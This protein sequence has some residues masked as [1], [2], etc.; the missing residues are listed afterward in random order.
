MNT[1][2]NAE[3]ALWRGLDDFS[4]HGLIDRIDP[5]SRIVA[6]VLFAGVVVSLGNL[7]AL[8]AGLGVGV[9][10]L[11]LS[12]T[13]NGATLKRVAAMD[14]FIIFMLVILPFTT[15]GAALFTIWGV[16][17][18]RE[19][20]LKAIEIMLKANAIVM[21]LL[22][23]VGSMEATTL[24]HGLYRLRCPEKLVHLMLFT[25]RYLS[26]LHDEYLRMR[27]AMR[28][29]G[30]LPRNNLHTYKSFGYLLGMMLVRSLERSER[31][32]EAMKCRGFD[33]RFF[34][35]A[36]GRFGLWDAVYAVIVLS[37]LAGLTVLEMLHVTLF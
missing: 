26:V 1:V 15:P 23:Q 25:V 11:G 14:A 30:F 33:G 22:S 29:R 13:L 16:P 36:D 24:G 9:L 20:L 31:I 6:G 12:G 35:L 5:R 28:T 8:S 3:K 27:T 34:L 37:L 2:T 21:V 7:V 10:A 17:A 18:S 4:S 32:Y 19:G